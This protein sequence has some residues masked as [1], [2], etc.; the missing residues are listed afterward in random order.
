MPSTET[1]PLIVIVGPTAVGK[2]EI[3]LQ[4]AER[5]GGE[6]VSADSRL[7]YRGMDIGTAKP[8]PADQNRVPHHLID[9]ADPD[10]PWSLSVFQEAAR[11][12]IADIHRRG[13]MPILVGGTG[14]YIRAVIEG[15]EPPAQGPNVQL[16][17]Y[18]ERWAG[19]IGAYEMH[20]RLRVLDP[21][22]ADRIDMTNVRR[23]IR[24]IEVA[25]ST[26]RRFSD[27]RGRT[28]PPFRT[29]VV[30]LIRPRVELY[31]RVDARIDGMVSGGLLDEVNLLLAKGY[32]PS[33][34]TLTA[35]GYR[36]GIAFV[37]GE[38]SLPDAIT[39]M[40]RLTR[41]YVRQ[42]SNWFRQE[43]EQIHWF[44]V[45]TGVEDSILNLIGNWKKE[46]TRSSG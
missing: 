10:E 45:K 15:W 25:L 3:S 21:I 1:E 23:T 11:A 5:I 43:D 39:Q 9:V 2:T 19:E 27:Q 40:K 4:I 7:F 28:P 24:A 30:G 20:Q 31:A 33:L 38:M 36:E 22:S 46:T 18:L 37:Q 26:G 13:K 8:S 16:R 29:L 44:T 41:R 34:G 6:I 14:Q 35:I 17:N 12:A 42:Q 32:S